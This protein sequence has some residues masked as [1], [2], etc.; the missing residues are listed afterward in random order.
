MLPAEGAVEL[1][2]DRGRAFS[3]GQNIA[4]RV[5]VELCA[6]CGEVCDV[7]LISRR[8]TI[9]REWV[10]RQI[11]NGGV[12]CPVRAGAKLEGRKIGELRAQGNRRAG[13]LL[14]GKFQ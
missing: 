4:R 12:G 2:V 11:R 6:G 5:E 1:Q 14:S 7:D 9:D 3:D 8:K 13:A 10:A